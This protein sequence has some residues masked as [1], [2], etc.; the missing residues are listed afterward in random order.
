[1]A[2][3]KTAEETA[4]TAEVDGASPPVAPQAKGK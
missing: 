4:A 1:M 3:K 2:K